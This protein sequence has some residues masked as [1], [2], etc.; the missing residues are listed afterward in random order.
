[1]KKRRP[2]AYLVKQHGL[3]EYDEIC[4]TKREAI[5]AAKECLWWSKKVTVTPLY[6]GRPIKWISKQEAR[7]RAGQAK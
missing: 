4:S 3:C 6:R 1:M 2:V 5:Q 7:R